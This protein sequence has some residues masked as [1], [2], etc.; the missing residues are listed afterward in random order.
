MFELFNDMGGIR[1]TA[2]SALALRDQIPTSSTRRSL[3]SLSMFVVHNGKK[4]SPAEF[5]RLCAAEA[6]ER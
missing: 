2:E 6:S 4:I 3:T 5:K 1:G